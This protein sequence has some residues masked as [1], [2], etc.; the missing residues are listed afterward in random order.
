MGDKAM[1]LHLIQKGHEN[2]RSTCRLPEILS[3]L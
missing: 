2:N 3:E 1:D